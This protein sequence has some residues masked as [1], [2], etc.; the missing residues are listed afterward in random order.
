[1]STKQYVTIDGNEAIASVA[2]RVSEV[3]AIYPIT[4]ASSM[5]EMPDDWAAQ[6]KTN[7]WGQI[8]D[9]V[10]MQSEGGASAAIHGATQA[11]ALCSTFTA[12]QG[13][14]LMV[15]TM[16]KVAGELSPVVIHVS[17]RTVATHA[18]SI[19]GDHSDVMACR[20]TGFALLASSGVQQNHDLAAIAHMS[21][22]RTRVP[23]VNFFDGF[24]TSHEIQKIAMLSDDDLR[25]LMNEE[26]IAEHRRRALSPD[27]PVLRGTAQNPP[28]F[29][30]AR[31][32]C[33]PFY[34]ACAGLVQ[35]E[36]NRFAEVAGRQYHL[37][38]YYGHPEAES[39]VIAMGSG[40]DT[41]RD[42]VEYL[43]RRGERVGAIEVHLYRPFA[44]Q[45]FLETLPRT[46]Q[47]I[48][49]LDRTKEPGAYAEPL[50]L[51]VLAV[52]QEN[53][54]GN[55]PLLI[56]GRYGL[57][58]KEFTPAMV[59]AVIDEFGKDQPKRRFTVG[60]DD[61]VTHL[62]LAYDPSFNL[63][64]DGMT[65]A[66]FFGLGADGTVGAN[67]NSIKIIGEGTDQEVQGYFVYD[68][69]KAGAITVS[70]LRFGPKSIRAPYLVQSADFVACHQFVFLERYDMLEC[71]KPGAVF[72]LNSPV[73]ADKVWDE[74][75]REVQEQIIEKKLK[76]YVID[77][78]QVARD[79]GM[80]G[81]INTVMQTCFFAISGVLP[82]DQAIAKIKEAIEKTYGRKGAD[83]VRKNQAA[84]DAAV[85]NLH[86]IPVPA[87]ATSKL[88]RPPVVPQEAP[89]FVQK[90]TAVM[91]VN[92]GD[93]LPVSAF[94][95]D[96]TWP[97]ATTQWEKRNIAQFI[98]V[99]D[100][101]ICIQCNKCVMVCAHAAIR[102]KVYDPAW[103]EKAPPTWKSMDFKGAPFK[104]QKYTVQVA[105]EDCT[106]CEL[107]AVICPAKDK[108][109]PSHKSLMMAEQRPLREPERENYEF[110]LQLPEV[111]R[112]QLKLDVKGT[113]FMRPLFEYSGAC[114][115][116]GETPYVK[117]MTQLFG[118]RALIGNATGCS[119][120]YGGNLPNT[121]YCVND[122]GRGPAWS[123]S[124]FED[125]AEFAFGFR[126]AID[127][128]NDLAKILCRQLASKLGDELVRALFEADQ[129][130]ELGIAAQRERVQ[131]LRSKLQGDRSHEARRLLGLADFLVKKS[132]WGVGGDGWA[133]DIGF[134]GLD[135]VLASN[136]DVNL[137]V[138]D[139]GVY[140]NTGGQQSKATPLGA[141]A[142]FA[143]AGRDVPRKDLGMFAMAYPNCYVAQ[144]AFG[145]RD[146]QTVNAFVEADRHPGPSIIIAYSHCIAHGFDLKA[147]CEHQ[148]MAVEAGLWP[149]YRSDPA[150][151]AKGE[152]PL[153]LDAGGTLKR[154][155]TD[156]TMSE[157]RFRMVQKLD[158]KRFE[159]LQI[160]AQRDAD[161]RTQLYRQLAELRIKPPTDSVE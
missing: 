117:L 114:A 84:V 131:A 103:L 121:P 54:P 69:K 7:I 60:I 51:D 76:F 71:A 68:S 155:V 124:L 86:E 138:L 116:C 77:A 27:R 81:R 6:G 148:K 150:R 4:P 13:L 139:T 17:A 108:A 26:L 100:E 144:V 134:G 12:S 57:S 110:F 62:S 42:T 14:L 147:G 161:R 2:F 46:T 90:V 18:L 11:G 93:T 75:P 143:A 132:V 56:N 87:A 36:M 48:A 83:V 95:P 105:P 89:E 50:F 106:G 52:L 135:H 99:W 45:T 112:T 73:P 37:F 58:C 133:Y 25:K 122:D 160:E 140:S 79:A 34:D 159:R 97:V 5:G 80:G 74:T 3:C 49:V 149:L 107:C 47:R 43:A 29:F 137:L 94:A 152:P 113:A 1:M 101:K 82:R 130:T 41:V 16:F 53:Q 44:A 55:V 21:T 88:T 141:A 120:I 9:V 96:G 118:D 123:N 40:A 136:R 63:E 33:N 111:D 19:F 91:L 128:Q 154:K 28:E 129:S 67:K 153:K 20:S 146:Q 151:A 158:P 39:I 23:F 92:K 157:T 64:P 85:G 142:K 119:S 115:G 24:R 78:Y 22:L 102:A 98:P 125:C 66:V 109:N 61:D 15:P 126:L 32:A 65:Q 38:D 59:K 104:G 10:E 30:Q 127:A 70:H 8:P 156:F 72:L 35:Q 31:E 145:A